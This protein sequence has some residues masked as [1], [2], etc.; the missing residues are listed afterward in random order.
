[1]DLLQIGC[2][3]VEPTIARQTIKQPISRQGGLAAPPWLFS[4]LI[5]KSRVEQVGGGGWRADA[6]VLQQLQFTRVGWS[7]VVHCI[8]GQGPDTT[9]VLLLRYNLKA[10]QHGTSR[11]AKECL[12]S[13][14]QQ[15]SKA[16]KLSPTAVKSCQAAQSCHLSTLSRL[17]CRPSIIK[18]SVPS[19]WL[20]RCR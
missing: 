13:C 9:L 16:V 12:P 3:G 17:P 10:P 7:P 6:V 8:R 19:P 2:I 18:L 11:Q 5:A 20:P 4:A 15:L 1:M 14:H